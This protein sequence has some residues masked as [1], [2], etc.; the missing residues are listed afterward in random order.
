MSIN[1]KLS[2][3]PGQGPVARVLALLGAALALVLAF[4][5]SLVFLAVVALAGLL[6]GGYVWWKT[7]ELRRQ[8]RA[9]GVKG[10]NGLGGLSGIDGLDGFARAAGQRDG[11]QDSAASGEIIEG[12]AVR[13]VDEKQRIGPV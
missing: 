10:T 11:A 2:P 8:L 13:V 4:T 3:Q 12:E 1:F 6:V 7:R 5:F 9:A